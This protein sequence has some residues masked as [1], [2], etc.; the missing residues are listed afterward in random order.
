[1]RVILWIIALGGGFVMLFLF[2]QPLLRCIVEGTPVDT[3]SGPKPIEDLKVGDQVWSRTH[4]GTLSPSTV[5]SVERDETLRYLRFTFV[6]G[7]RLEVTASHPIATGTGWTEAGDLSPEQAMMGRFGNLDITA[8]ETVLSWQAVYDISVEPHSNFFANGVLV[9]NK[10]PSR[11]QG[12]AIGDTRTVISALVTYASAN[13]GFFPGDLTDTTREDGTP[14]A[15]PNY[16]DEAPEFM[17]RDLGQPS[18][19]VKSGYRRTYQTFGRPEDIPPECAQNSVFDFCY[20][21][22][23]LQTFRSHLAEDLPRWLA[24]SLYFEK[25]HSFVATSDGAIYMDPEGRDLSCTDGK[26]PPY[27]VP[28]Q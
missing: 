22:H 26:P 14:I 17:G 28:L 6:D 2:F 24:E 10:S 5:V 23:P 15:I 13:C 20:A 4:N 8:I 12:R 27:A 25:F 19:Y 3:P 9:H 21:S 1:M 11:P 16:P 7:R 18:P